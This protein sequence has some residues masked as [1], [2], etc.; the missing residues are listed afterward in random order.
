MAS[1]AEV[2][3]GG[4]RRLRHVTRGAKAEGAACEL[5]PLQRTWQS[6]GG[7]FVTSNCGRI[8]ALL[9][10]IQS[11]FLDDPALRL[12]LPRAQV[13]FGV[14][15]VTG[16]AVLGALVDAG[17]LART[18]DGAYLRFLPQ[19]AYAAAPGRTSEPRPARGWRPSSAGHAA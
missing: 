3:R 5:L 11:D 10:R 7:G 12:T 2:V 13:R 9:M 1:L 17:V 19:A 8:Q 15:A 18:P 4:V 6:T 16:E 14:D